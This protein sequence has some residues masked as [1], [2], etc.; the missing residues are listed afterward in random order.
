MALYGMDNRQ[1]PSSK[2]LVDCE[3]SDGQQELKL[4]AFNKHC[5]Y[6]PLLIGRLSDDLRDYKLIYRSGVEVDVVPGTSKKFTLLEY[7]EGVGLPYQS[8]H[9]G[10]LFTGKDH[11]LQQHHA[12]A[13]SLCTCT[14]CPKQLHKSESPTIN[15]T[16]LV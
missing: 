12:L 5:H 13:D 14:S 4:K 2:L 11:L 9:F 1:I 6:N 7:K 3:E 8:L 16:G 15:P 10:L